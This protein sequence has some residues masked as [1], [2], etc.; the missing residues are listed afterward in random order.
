[1]SDEQGKSGLDRA[2]EA[3]KRAQHTHREVEALRPEAK[4]VAI[5][6]FRERRRNGLADLMVVAIRKPSP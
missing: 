5:D 6:A 4:K 3:L 2:L 1:M